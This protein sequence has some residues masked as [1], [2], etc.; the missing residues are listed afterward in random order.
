MPRI[1]KHPLTWVILALIVMFGVAGV[2]GDRHGQQHE[3]RTSDRVNDARVRIVEPPPISNPKRDE[4]R[5]EQDLLA[6]RQMADWAKF[7]VLVAIAS[8]F[9]TAVGVVFVA[10]TLKA[11]RDAVRETAKATRATE[12]AVDIQV[13]I[14]HPLLF[15][16]SI[17]LRM[18]PPEEEYRLKQVVLVVRNVGR[19]P[20]ILTE[21]VAQCEALS[22]LPRE[23]HRTAMQSNCAAD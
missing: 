7:A 17:G 20:A 5:Q 11:T 21:W 6:Q 4:W 9:V 8:V 16:E 23:L 22:D 2:L 1:I 10:L 15:V 3:Q 13:R 19:G 18:D 12:R 14:E